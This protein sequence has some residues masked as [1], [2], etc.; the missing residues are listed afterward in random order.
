MIKMARR[1]EKES[2]ESKMLLQIHDELV[3][4]VPPDELEAMETIVHEE[5]ESVATL[6]VPL[7]VDVKCGSTWAEI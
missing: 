6:K 4:E 1:M 7:K 2:V 3:F 5:M